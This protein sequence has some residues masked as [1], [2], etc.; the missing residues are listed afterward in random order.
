MSFTNYRLIYAYAR[1]ILMREKQH[2]GPSTPSTGLKR[3]VSISPVYI[4]YMLTIYAAWPNP[5]GRP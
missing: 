3:K 4:W 1:R 5:P 2:I